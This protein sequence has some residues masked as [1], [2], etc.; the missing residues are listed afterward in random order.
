MLEL[1]HN[2]QALAKVQLQ[3]TLSEEDDDE[4]GG[5]KNIVKERNMPPPPGPISETA[6]SNVS[7]LLCLDASVGEQLRPHLFSLLALSGAPIHAV[8]YKL[9]HTIL[10]C[11][12]SES[13][14]SVVLNDRKMMVHMTG[15]IK[16]F[17]AM[18]PVSPVAATSGGDVG[19]SASS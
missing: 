8:E 16:G 4:T 19:G 1:R 17:C 13:I 12:L 3:G 14:V 7:R 9:C 2:H 18:T 10:L 5:D 11:Q 15:D 6:A